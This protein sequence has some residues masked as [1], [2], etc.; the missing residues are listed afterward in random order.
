MRP[1]SNN[2]GLRHLLQQQPFRQQI[3]GMSQMGGNNPR[4]QMSQQMQ[5]TGNS[6]VPFD[7]VANF[8]FM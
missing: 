8:D 2:P 4:P 1:A 5:N 6:G 7:D 3:M